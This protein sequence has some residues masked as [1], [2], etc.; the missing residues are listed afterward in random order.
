MKPDHCLQLAKTYFS[1]TMTEIYLN[2]STEMTLQFIVLEKVILDTTASQS[3]FTFVYLA[4]TI[5]TNGLLKSIKQGFP[6][7]HC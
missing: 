5:K 1:V 6:S 3:D 4:L 7:I 2:H